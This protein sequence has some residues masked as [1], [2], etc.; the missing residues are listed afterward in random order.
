[1]YSSRLS[2]TA[3]SFESETVTFTSTNEPGVAPPII[4]TV[5]SPKI[6]YG[7]PIGLQIPSV[8][9]T[10]P[11]IRGDI[12]DGEWYVSEHAAHFATITPQP[13]T[14]NGNTIIYAHNRPHLFKNTLNVKKGD[15]VFIFTNEGL[16]FEYT[17]DHDWIVMP[18]NTT[19]FNIDG[20]PQVTLL[21]CHGAKDEFRRLL[22]FKLKAV[23]NE[24]QSIKV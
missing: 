9:I 1:M 3:K 14:F 23:H 20:A 13:N 11:I 2:T 7:W 8:N 6:E 5:G 18:T 4:E 10:V 22:F 24:S 21:T 19:V 16:T 15:S 17:Y 12:I